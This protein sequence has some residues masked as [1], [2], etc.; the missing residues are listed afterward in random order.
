MVLEADSFT[1]GKSL[2]EMSSREQSWYIPEFIE[3]AFSDICGNEGYDGACIFGIDTISIAGD[4]IVDMAA[5]SS[6]VPI[7]MICDNRVPGWVSPNIAG[8]VLSFDGDSSEMCEVYGELSSRGCHIFCITCGGT[9]AGL[10]REDG[11]TLIPIPSGCDQFGATGYALGAIAALVQSMGLFPAK[12]ILRR[13]LDGVRSFRESMSEA[14][15]SLS[16]QLSGKMVATYS[17]SDIHSCSK[18]WKQVLQTDLSF[19]GEL[20]EFDHNELVGWSDSNEHARDLRIVVLW[21]GNASEL[22][23]TIVECMIEVL[24]ENGRETTVVNL[25][26]GSSAERNLCGIILGDAVSFCMEVG[27]E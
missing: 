22:V 17:T 15:G 21:G 12:D 7:P 13:S 27:P 1:D 20:P 18:R 16:T 11:N 25:G 19:Y 5:E 23:S 6:E 24:H 9:I 26:N 3:L 8:I 4:V 14:V 10:C 2:S